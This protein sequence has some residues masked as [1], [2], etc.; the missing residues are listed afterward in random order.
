MKKIYKNP[1]TE[2]VNIQVA[3]II[4]SSPNAELYGV[5]ATSEGMSRRDRNDWDDDE[6]YE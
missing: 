3:T 1:T 6:D 5:N 2:V 4:A